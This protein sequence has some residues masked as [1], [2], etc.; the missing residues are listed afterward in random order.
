MHLRQLLPG[1]EDSK[2][3]NPLHD[4]YLRTVKRGY[5]KQ[6]VLGLRQFYSQFISEGDLVF[7]V[8]ANSGEYSRAFLALGAKVV[9][10]EP[11]PGL[12]QRLRN[13]AGLTVKECAMGSQQGIL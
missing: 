3:F 4:L 6:H 7:D 13:I 5:W 12:V 11:T 8:G 10:I 1:I 9:A 2:Y